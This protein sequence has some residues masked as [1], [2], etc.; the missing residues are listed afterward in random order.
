MVVLVDTNVLLDLFTDDKAWAVW[1]E[2][3]IRDAAAGVNPIIYAEAS[4]G[5]PIRAFWIGIWMRRC[6]FA[7]AFP[8]RP[9]FRPAGCQATSRGWMESSASATA[10]SAKASS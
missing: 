1:S 9:R 6:W 10:R 2:R 4:L 3:A 5:F 8:T 7:P